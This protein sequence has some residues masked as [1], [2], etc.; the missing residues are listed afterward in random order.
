MKLRP[1]GNHLLVRRAEAA[2]VIGSIIIPQ[3]AQDAPHRGKVIAAGPGVKNPDGVVIPLDVAE[4]DV[5]IFGARMGV[6]VTV[7][8]EELLFMTEDAVLAVVEGA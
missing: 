5:V 7:G 8:G 4:G 3:T 1:L 2:E 6:P